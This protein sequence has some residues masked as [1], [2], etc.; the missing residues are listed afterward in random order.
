MP[1]YMSIYP[2]YFVDEFLSFY[3]LS[4][5]FKDEELMEMLSLKAIFN[6]K[7]KHLSKGWH[8]RLK[9]YTALCN[10]KAIIILDEP[11]DGFDPLQLRDIINIFKSQNDKGRSFIMSIHQ[12]TYAQKICDYF[13]LL[14]DGQMIA[15]GRFDKLEAQFQC[16]NNSLEEIFLKALEK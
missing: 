5:N 12:L 6:K 14:N 8:Q 15:K 11:F 2:E 13:V 1:E 9:L 4:V 16:N 10:D 7:I 3:H